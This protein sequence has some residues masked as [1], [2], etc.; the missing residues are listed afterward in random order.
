MVFFIK[1]LNKILALIERGAVVLFFNLYMVL[2]LKHIPTLLKVIL[3]LSSIRRM[4][5]DTSERCRYINQLIDGLNEILTNNTK[6]NDPV[7]NRK[8]NFKIF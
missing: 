8:V 7:R 6:L 3:Q 5:F 1:K 4:I 2:D